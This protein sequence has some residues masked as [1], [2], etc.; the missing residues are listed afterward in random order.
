MGKYRNSSSSASGSRRFFIYLNSVGA[1]AGI[2][3]FLLNQFIIK[4]AAHIF[5]F[6]SFFNDII[7]AFLLL[8][9]TN[10]IIH[11]LRK[12]VYAVETLFRIVLLILS[13]GLFWEYVTPLYRTGSYS[14]PLDLLAYL[15]GGI[16]YWFILRISVYRKREFVR[17]S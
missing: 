3:L 7:A 12:P 1:A 14:D 6:H 15:S 13:A 4:P 5:F 11:L 10:L 9:Y 2:F 16:L 8:C 17:R